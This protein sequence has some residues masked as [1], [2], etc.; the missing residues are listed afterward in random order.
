MDKIVIE[1]GIPLKGEVTISGSKNA[2][3]PIM[4]AC[5]LTGGWHI[6]DNIPKLRDIWTMKEILSN[7][8]VAFQE[9]GQ[10]LKVNTDNLNS[11]IAPY[12]LVKTMRASIL[13]L[14]PLLSRMG[15]AKISLP[16]GCAIGARPIDLHLKG[17]S[18]MGA[19][20][21]LEHGYVVAQ[22]NK[23]R[24]A[25]I[26]FDIP[27]VTGTEN[28]MV[29]AVKADGVTTLHNAA[30]E[31]EVTDLANM[32]KEMGAT[33]NGAGT[34]TITINGVKELHSV[35][36]TIIPDRIEAGTFL[37]AAAITKGKLK[38]KGCNKV[39]VEA[40][41]E[42]LLETG[43]EIN[44]EGEDLVVIGQ[45][46]IKSANIK[47]MPFPGFPT[48]M[49][50]QFMA[51]MSIA[52]GWSI[53]RESIFENRFMHVSE[54]RRMGADIKIHGDQA[55]VLGKKNLSGAQVMATDLRASA[56]LVLAGLVAKGKTEIS[57]VYH[58]DRGYQD[59][60]VKLSLLGSKIWREKQ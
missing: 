54:L 22:A 26:F 45:D 8:G 17:L 16:G 51:L 46:K 11:H 53:I 43:T 52:D 47:T 49:Q 38:I 3:L 24:G 15:K 55:L 30:K 2:A 18:L 6:L 19:D 13:S 32:L 27:T 35:N 36:Y 28:L 31:P 25:D 7:L 20:I 21:H 33:I 34:D 29:A 1:G 57:R 10:C 5:L 39:H 41:I 44:Q 14:G 60:D 12:K 50:A 23:L 48:D 56:S 37:I 58:L 9:N 4:S 42:K 40:I 59:L